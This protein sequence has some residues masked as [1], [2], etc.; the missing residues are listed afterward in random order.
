MN[1]KRRK[2]RASNNLLKLIIALAVALAVLVT[3]VIVLDANKEDKPDTP[4][5][6]T[7]PGATV[8]TT[9]P[10]VTVGTEATGSAATEPSETVAAEPSETGAAAQPTGAQTTAP[11]A[12]E[13]KPVVTQLVATQPVETKP[14]PKGEAAIYVESTQVKKDAGE[15]AVN[16]RI[17]NNPGILGAVVKV[18]V[19]DKVFSLAEGRKT[20]YPGLTLTAPGPAAT[21]SPYTFMLDALEL[22]GDD[23]QDGTLFT[24]VFKLRDDAA[25][26]TYQV[27]LSCD[28]GAVF[29]EKY[30]DVKVVLENGTITVG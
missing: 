26:G 3:V 20:Q 18:S 14:V 10:T 25:A 23:R 12:A 21:G 22:T 6:E 2:R 29:D 24:I 16:I 7:K 4:T 17:R 19:D 30:K 11:S 13:T 27:E 28:K 1:P 5:Q 15:V 9:A 8:S